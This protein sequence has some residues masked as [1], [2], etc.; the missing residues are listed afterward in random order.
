MYRTNVEGQTD[1][2]QERSNYETDAESDNHIPSN[3][4]GLFLFDATS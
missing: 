3:G 2:P 4:F 1:L